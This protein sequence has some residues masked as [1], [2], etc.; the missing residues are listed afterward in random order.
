MTAGSDCGFGARSAALKRLGRRARLLRFFDLRL[1]LRAIFRFLLAAH[2]DA[3]FEEDAVG[4][5]E[6]LELL[7]RFCRAHML[8]ADGVHRVA[9]HLV[10]IVGVDCAHDLALNAEHIGLD[11]QHAG[12]EC[13]RFQCVRFGFAMAIKLEAAK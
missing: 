9:E 5:R 10:D 11:Q 3:G 7:A 1:E 6:A 8:G 13:A 12:F 2:G 4:E